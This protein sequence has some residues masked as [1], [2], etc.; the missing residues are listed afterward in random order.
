MEIKKENIFLFHLDV[1]FTEI[2]NFCYKI[3][4]LYYQIFNNKI[5]L[6]TI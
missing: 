6:N 3:Y 4:T 5:S 2:F 1:I